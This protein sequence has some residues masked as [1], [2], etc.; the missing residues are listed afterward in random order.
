M[1][2]YWNVLLQP[3]GERHRHVVHMFLFAFFISSLSSVI[4]PSSSF[5]DV[6]ESYFILR[7]LIEV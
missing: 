4:S 5:V 6:P 3:A 2:D 7:D 1:N